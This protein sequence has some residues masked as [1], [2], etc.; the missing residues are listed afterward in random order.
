MAK[1]VLVRVSSRGFSLFRDLAQLLAKPTASSV[2]A[3]IN[4]FFASSTSQMRQH[5]VSESHASVISEI[6]SFPLFFST[7]S[8]TSCSS[9]G[10]IGSPG[11][12]TG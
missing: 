7:S 1:I 9:I 8:S 5:S 6:L 11:I 4:A 12:L 10:N 2:L 3:I